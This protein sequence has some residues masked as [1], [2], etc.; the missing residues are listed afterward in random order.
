MGGNYEN[1]R[2]KKDKLLELKEIDLVL[3]IR[4]INDLID[5]LVDT[6][7]NFIERQE[8]CSIKRLVEKDGAFCV[9]NITSYRQIVKSKNTILDCHINIK[10]GVNRKRKGWIL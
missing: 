2:D 9:E 6:R 7:K 3:T 4:E 1:N 8:D 10:I 5:F